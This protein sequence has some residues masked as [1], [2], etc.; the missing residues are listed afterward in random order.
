MENNNQV[1]Y[2]K[3]DNNKIINEKCITWAKRIGECMEVCTKSTGCK[4]GIDTHKI[5]K[6]YNPISYEKLNRYFD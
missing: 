3:S 6:I 5:C 4:E 2:L 1:S